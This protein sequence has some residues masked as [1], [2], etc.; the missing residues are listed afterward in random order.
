MTEHQR[1][2]VDTGPR[3]RPIKDAF[4]GV[5]TAI[6]AAGSAVTALVGFGV[7][8]IAQGDA[9]TGLL[10]IIPGVLTALTGVLSAYGVLGAA[11]HETTPVASPRAADGT[12][13]V[14]LNH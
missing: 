9:A 10:G 1:F 13:L 7:L 12:T 6:T 3:P 14:P 5:G 2:T 8:T 11:E 4:R